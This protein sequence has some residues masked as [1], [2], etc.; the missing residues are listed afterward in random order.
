[1][2]TELLTVVFTTFPKSLPESST[3]ARRFFRACFVCSLMPPVTISPVAGSSGMFPETNKRSLNFMAWE[4]G[5]TAPGAS[6]AGFVKAAEEKNGLTGGEDGGQ[7]WIGR[8]C[9]R[10]CPLEG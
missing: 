5:P 2:K 10:H 3:T 9:A 8:D 1:M 4:Y 7:G 6:T